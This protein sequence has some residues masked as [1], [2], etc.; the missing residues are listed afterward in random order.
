MSLLT[1]KSVV[2]SFSDTLQS[3]S[4][5]TDTLTTNN[6]KLAKSPAAGYFM[7]CS[8]ITGTAQ[9]TQ[10]TPGTGTV[11]GPTPSTD[12]AIATW[13]GTA[14]N[15]LKSSLVT[16]SSNGYLYA[17]DGA[18][19]LPAYSFTLDS[20]TGVYL[21]AL[22]QLSLSAG[23][24]AGITLSTNYN[25][26]LAGATSSFAGGTGCVFIN[27]ATTTPAGSFSGG[28]GILYV[29]GTSLLFLNSSGVAT[30]LTD[31]VTLDTTQTVSG[32]KTFSSAAGITTTGAV[33]LAGGSGSITTSGTVSAGVVT[34][35][36]GSTT[37]PSHSFSTS[38]NSGLYLASAG[39]VC[40]TAG[41]NTCLTA[42]VSSNVALA[43]SVASFAGGSGCVFI[44]AATTTPA[45]SFSGGG[46]LYVSGTSL[47]FLNSSGVATTLTDIVTLDTTQ[48]VSGAKTFSAAAGITTTGAVSLAGGSGSITTSGTVSAGVVTVANGSTTTPSHS[49]STSTNS[50]LYLASAGNV[51]ITAGG[52]T[53]LTANVSS[54]VA[55]A[56]A[57]PTD[58][59][60]GSGCVYIHAV[61]TAPTTAA[62]S[63]TGGLLYV[64]G[65][66]LYF[67]NSAGT[68]I[69]LSSQGGV[70]GPGS[71]TSNA[72]ACWSSVGVLENSSITVSSGALSGVSSITSTG[73]AAITLGA[74]NNVSLISPPTAAL[75]AITAGKGVIFIAPCTTVPVGGVNFNSGGL[76]FLAGSN[77]T[78]LG[79]GGVSKVLNNPTTNIA[80]GTVV[81]GATLT[82][83]N[84]STVSV[85]LATSNAFY[86]DFMSSYIKIS[87]TTD[88]NVGNTT[89]TVTYTISRNS[90]S[91][92][93]FTQIFVPKTT[94]IQNL[95]NFSYI[96]SGF[97][98]GVIYTVT[99][100]IASG[101]NGSITY[102]SNTAQFVLEEIIVV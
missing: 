15:L 49:F 55:L 101:G 91:A 19:S 100:T 20:T 81:S 38:T 64:S 50:G 39:N 93:I 95:F 8:D 6:L 1:E 86:A 77:L 68:F 62:N 44:N 24:H 75:G 41:G 10:I 59:G 67:L 23:G 102:S 76:L 48:T 56:G 13:N 63:G 79:P 51:C 27:A 65:A 11:N 32:A 34:V 88:Y 45:G 40:I 72:I 26:A 18:V 70:T 97:S 14:G 87:F 36:N 80:F 25:V 30:T 69:N 28:G 82:A 66:S 42:N 94:Y 29:S 96:D 3:A 33:S 2:V 90:P 73:T 4:I 61:S 52:N 5:I 57:T 22:N 60:G 58:Y 21:S 85:V 35:A 74:D 54:N 92:T 46:I 9:W 53:C 47:M 83:T 99:A 7:Q 17:A 37:T 43:G 98:Y 31:I 12:G 84:G 16:I 71:V 78:F 89:N